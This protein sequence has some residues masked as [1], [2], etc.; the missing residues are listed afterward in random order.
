MR[1]LLLLVVPL[2]VLA[3]C[4]SGGRVNA[5][6]VER[7]VKNRFSVVEGVPVR[8][9]KCPHDVPKRTGTVFTCVT[10]MAAEDP[11]EVVVT[12]RGSDRYTIVPALSAHR[13]ETLLTQRGFGGAA[14]VSVLGAQCPNG[15]PYRAGGTLTC[16]VALGGG[17]KVPVRVRQTDIRGTVSF[18][19]ATIVATEVEG[20]IAAKLGSG[21]RVM[22]PRGIP[23]QPGRHFVCSAHD[24]RTRAVSVVVLDRR[25]DVRF[26]AA[27]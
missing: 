21:V 15:V 14:H 1:P 4:G 16:Q 8:D 17:E 27:R 7:L 5:G 13:L 2:A 3:G 19:A 12:V 10:G 6:D 24:G 25:G 23:I 9:V 18:A 22:C 20:D 11:V 26:S